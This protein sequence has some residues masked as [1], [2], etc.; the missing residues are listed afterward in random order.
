M[1]LLPYIEEQA[2]SDSYDFEVNY[3]DEQLGPDG[4]P[5]GSNLVA[6]FV[7]PSDSHPGQASHDAA[8]KY[9]SID[10]LKTYKMSNYQASR[11]PTQ[12]INGGGAVCSLV[13]TFNQALGPSVQDTPPGNLSYLYP[14]SFPECTGPGMGCFRQFG[15]PFTRL[16]H[17]VSRKQI[18]DGESHTIYMGEVRPQCSKHAA[19]GWGY[20][21]SGN[22]I[23]GT[24]IP[25]NFDSCD[26]EN[27]ARR[28]GYWD[29]WVTD[30]G[31]KSAH[32]GGALF[33]LGDASVQF[34]PESI[35]MVV[36]NAL[37]GKSDAVPVSL[38]DF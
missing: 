28:C 15:G 5:L 29:T 2:L 7:C 13:N 9:L 8:G 26:S 33:V 16:S 31:F 24:L 25:I 23:V 32:S 30:F 18:T 21:H 6:S 38:S 35:D 37:G 34:L 20:S 27:S 19:E 1:F 36:Y 3:V 12:Q 11:G 17:H 4:L 10:Q 14:D 22:G